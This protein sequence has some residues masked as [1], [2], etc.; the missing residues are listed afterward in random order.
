MAKAKVRYL[1]VKIKGR[2]E[3]KMAYWDIDSGKEGPCLLV[4]AAVHGN[5][6]QGSEVIRRFCP[7]A[8]KSIVKGRMIPGSLC[9]S[10]R[11]VEQEAPHN[12]NSRRT[13][14]E[15]GEKEDKK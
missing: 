12:I 5:E 10:P 13:K 15:I 9:E 8:E 4:T 7:V 6:V 1:P 3:F 2:P 14:G 11:L